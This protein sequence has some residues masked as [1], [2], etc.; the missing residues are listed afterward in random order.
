MSTARTSEPTSRRYGATAALWCAPSRPGSSPGS[1]RDARPTPD[2]CLSCLATTCPATVPWQSGSSVTWQGVDADLAS[3]MTASVAVVTTVADRIT[4]HTTAEDVRTV[5]GFTGLDDHCPVVT[6][7][8][9]EWV[10]S[11][12]F[13][14]GRPRWED[15]GATFACDVTPFEHRKLWL[16]NGAHSLLAYAGSIRGHTTVAAAAADETCRS[17]LD[18]WWAVASPHLAQPADQIASY[19][20]GLMERFD[21][22]RM[23]DRLDRIAADG[24]QKLPVRVLPVLRAERV[25]GR[26]PLGATRVLAAWVCHLRGFGAPVNDARADEVVPLAEGPLPE[27][28]KRVL[29]WLDPQV[30][31]DG[32]VT[33]AVLDQSRQ[34]A[35]HRRR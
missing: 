20:A 11:G 24:S 3:W 6:E 32:D 30:G 19:R 25:A 26:L 22:S 16:L 15:A 9:H 18:E 35:Q 23:H 31:G 21:N 14:S 4:P 33:A 28:V 12:E 2:R 29:R 5:A 27:A 10:L 1:Q 17:W 13:P 34:L 7:P 8:F